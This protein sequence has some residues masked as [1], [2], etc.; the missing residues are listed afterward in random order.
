MKL[1]FKINLLYHIEFK[2]KAFYD[3]IFFMKY[4]DIIIDISH[5]R[6]DKTFEYIV[7]PELENEIHEGV[8]VVIPFGA[9]NRA[10]TGYVVGL[11]DKPQFDVTKL[12]PIAR[13]VK[14]SIAIESQLI[15]L[16]AFLKRNYGSTMNQALKTVI[17]I[18]KKEN[19]KLKKEI[20]LAVSTNQARI[21]LNEL[22]T[23]KRHAVGKER[24]LK[25]L[26]EVDVL[27]WELA[28]KKL[29]IP[30]SNIRDLESKGIVKIDSVR[31]FRNPHLQADAT[32]G[33]VTLNEEQEAAAEQ[34]KADIDTGRHKT[35]L[36]H[37]V[38]GSGKTEVYMDVMEHVI[39][40]GK[41]VIVLIPEIALTYQTVMRFYTRFGDSVSILNSRMSPGERFD[42]FERAKSGEISIMVGP[43]SALFTPFTNLGL[44][45][46]DEEHEPSYKSEV[47]P[48]YHARETAVYRASLTGATVI[49]GSA[50][51]SLE[52]YSRAVSG[53]YQLITLNN[54][55]MGQDMAQ[56]EIVDLRAELQSGNRSMLSRRLKELMADR[57]SKNQQ[58][59]LFL[60]RR[61]LM[62]FVSCRACGHV[63][64]C[65]HCDVAL[66]LHAGGIMKCHYC[67]YTT[68]A[69][70]TC[71]SCGSKYIGSFKAGTQRLEEIVKNAFPT[72][73]VLRMDADTTSGKNGHEEILSAFA[74]HE[75]DVL[76]GT[77]MIVKGHDFANVT[78]VGIIAAD[79]SLNE[80]DF[81]SGERTFQ[82]LTQ[83][84]GRAGRG[85]EPGIAVIQ[86]Y[87][88]E[89]YAVVTSA[90]QD[91]DSFFK[92][93]F[94]YRRLLQYPP[95]SHILGIQVSSEK[96]G[97]A[98]AQA[99]I[100]A[101][102][103]KQTDPEIIIMGPE[104]AYIGKLKDIYRRVIYVKADDY[105]RLVRVKDEIDKF[106]LEQKEYRSTTTWFD[107][108]PIS[109]I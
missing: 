33:R 26:L 37:G 5:E 64:K 24:L 105:D 12:K 52:A 31:T 97:D 102:V 21:E 60:N 80:S 58:I 69:A 53:E 78:L 87:Q 99:D 3:K 14:D 55:A 109:T 73:R 7:P 9:G 23:N 43:R 28:T 42:Q 46:I 13:V 90:N 25:E 101:S 88:P 85:T 35:Y 108:D 11:H 79:I 59:M 93:E 107:F 57:L 83:A 6:L 10:I 67:G 17:P 34:I 94:A 76:I 39:N 106:L 71:P 27:D 66:H 75:A 103:I 95:C 32:R 70:K 74:A 44:I 51:P 98:I 56:C 89:N 40:M 2:I 86:T 16:A 62:G 18:K 63:L 54:R 68:K 96:Q 91:Y 4:A 45:I 19:E 38:T 29:Q 77:Q 1:V 84:V 8:Q 20:S 49:L 100:L 72:A 65:P 48:R 92:Q 50:T 30:S 22:L 41:Q 81:H 104:D 82:L 61:G 47:V 36:I 15:S